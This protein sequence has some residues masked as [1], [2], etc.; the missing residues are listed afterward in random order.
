MLVEKRW[1]YCNGPGLGPS[2]ARSPPCEHAGASEQP[3]LTLRDERD[4][5]RR[6]PRAV[7]LLGYCSMPTLRW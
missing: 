3:R 4:E 6:L 1:S 7:Y 2:L 5:L